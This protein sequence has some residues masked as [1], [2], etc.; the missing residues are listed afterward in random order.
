MQNLTEEGESGN[1]AHQNVLWPPEANGTSTASQDTTLQRRFLNVPQRTASPPAYPVQDDT[2]SISGTGA[3]QPAPGTGTGV[4]EKS[5]SSP[6]NPTARGLHLPKQQ[7]PAMHL[8]RDQ[9]P[10]TQLPKV[11]LP[12]FQNFNI[13]RFWKTTSFISLKTSS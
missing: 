12:L 5:K 8:T 11:K 6:I 2:E 4:S 7:I 3:H 1:T 9:D 10:R 13:R